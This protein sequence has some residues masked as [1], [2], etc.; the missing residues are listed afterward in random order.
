VPRERHGSFEPQLSPK[1]QTRWNGFDDK[2]ISLYARG[3]TV[4]EIQDHLRE[5]QGTEVSP[6]LTSSMADAAIDEVKVWRAHP[7]GANYPI[8]YLDCIHVKARKGAV[9]IKAVYLAIGVNMNGEK[10]G[11]GLWLAQTE[12]AKF[13]LQVVTDLRN[14]GVQDIFIACVEGLKGFSEAMVAVLSKAV[15]QLCLVH[16]VRHSLNDVSWKRRKDVAADLRR[17]YQ[18]ATA[19]QAELRPGK[20]EVKWDSDYLPIGQSWRRNWSRLTPFFDYPA[21]IR[22]VIYTTNAI[23]SLNMGLRKLSKNR[24]SFPCDEALTK[25]CYRVLRNIRQKWPMPIRD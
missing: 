2:I 6:R 3:T 11:L 16:M 12:G 10:G 19:E 25:L 13:W 18:A 1:H 5:M 15:V 9:R 24:G 17:I 21:E 7:L 4:R 8:V 14:R 22:K 23:E 20:F